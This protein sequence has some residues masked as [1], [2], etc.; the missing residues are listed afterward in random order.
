MNRRLNQF[1]MS[2]HGKPVK[3]DVDIPIGATGAVGTLAGGQGITSV[4]RLVAGVYQINLS[5]NYKYYLGA[6]FDVWSPVS[7][8]NVAAT[9][10]NVGSIY[11]IT[12]LGTTTQANWVTAGVPST[13]TAAVGTAFKCAA[14]SSGNGTAKIQGVSSIAAVEVIGNPNATIASN[15]G[16]SGGYIIIQCLAATGAG[17]TT[18][19]ATD[20]ASGSTLSIELYL[21]DSSIGSQAY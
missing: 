14:T 16:T 13:V 9:A 17:T 15:V 2:F 21:S 8:S 1:M 10:L 19:V 7:G 6:S 4:T 11:S 18:L 3:L 12:A 20:P 5:D